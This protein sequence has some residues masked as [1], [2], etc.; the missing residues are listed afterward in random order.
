M[1][2][3]PPKR[4]VEQRPMVEVTQQG[5]KRANTDGDDPSDGLPQPGFG[6]DVNNAY[7][8]EFEPMIE[9]VLGPF[10]GIQDKAP[11][12]ISQGGTQDRITLTKLAEGMDQRG[13]VEGGGNLF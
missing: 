12:E 13:T 1:S 9:R 7:I 2:K 8:A 11:L 6:S 10:E 5:Q 3:G 4:V